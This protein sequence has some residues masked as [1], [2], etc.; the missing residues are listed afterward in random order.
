MIDVRLL[1][2]AEVFSLAGLSVAESIAF[3]PR[4]LQSEEFTADDET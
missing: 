4:I 2:G 1:G 3:P